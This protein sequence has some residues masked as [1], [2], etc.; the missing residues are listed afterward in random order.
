[1]KSLLFGMAALALLVG[2]TSADA[3]WVQRPTLR[4]NPIC[5][6]NVVIVERVWVPEVVPCA[7]PVVACAPPVV[8]VAPA[9]ETISRHHH[10]YNHGYEL[11]VHYR[12]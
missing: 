11:P 5:G 1:M 9:C 12:H 6:R 2:S 7:P 3:A 8:V 4:W 10:H